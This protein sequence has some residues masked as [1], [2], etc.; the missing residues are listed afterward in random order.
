[1]QVGVR[2][3]PFND[4]EKALNAQLCVDCEGPTTILQNPP[5]LA[6][7]SGKGKEPKKFTFDAS[8]WSHDGFENDERGYSKALPGSK[9][10]DQQLVFDTF[11]KKI[12]DNAWE[13][14]HCTL[15]AY[16]QTGA[17]K[18]YSMVGYGANKGIVPISCEEIFRRIE[19]NTDAGLT[20]EV[21]VS[22]VEIYN[23]QVQDLLVRSKDRPKK[24]LDIREHNELGIYIVGVSKRAVDS[25]PAIEAVVDEGTH[26]RTVGSTLMN[27]TSSRAHTVLTIEFKQISQV[28]GQ[29]GQKLSLINLVDLA[30]SEK[31][32]QTGASGDRL[33]EGCAI[34]K[35]LSALGNVIEKLADKAT[36]KAK[37]GAIIPYRDSKLTRLLQNA[38]GGSS[39]TVM[40]CAISPASSNYEET[41]S[42]LRYADRAKRIKNT[43]AI[44]ENPQD[45]LI[46]QLREE[47]EKLRN[48]VGTGSAKGSESPEEMAAKAA[49]IAALEHALQE[50]Q[51]SFAE[52][53]SAAQKQAAA[54]KKKASSD[55]KQP[56]IANLNEDLLLTAKL[57]FPFKEGITRVGRGSA[58]EGD[59]GPEV[60]LQVPG[61]LQEH[62][63]V[64]NKE[65]ICSLT[66]KGEAALT[67]LINGTAVQDGVPATLNHGDRLA[68]GQCI[69]IFVEPSQ[70]KVADLINSGQV[71]YAMARKELQQGEVSGGPTE[72]EIK[73]S[74]E[75]AEELERK[76]REAE[77]AKD[78]AKA[79]AEELLKKREEEFKMQMEMKQKQWQEEI[80]QRKAAEDSEQLAAT[81]AAAEQA[82][83]HAEEVTRLQIEFE[84]RQ[85]NQ[86]EM[87]SRKI[88]ELERKAKKAAAEE[89]GHRQHELAMQKL[90][91]QLMTV[92]PL[93]KEANL[94]I[95][96]LQRPHRLE[97]K[98]HCE[99]TAEGKHGAVNVAAAV[100]LNG[101]RLFE[102]NP[103]TLENRVFILREL[104]QRAEEESLEVIKDLPQEEDPLWDPIQVERLIGV[105][106]VL[107]EGVLL[108]VE[109]KVD[110]RILS[111]E[112]QA[113][114]TMKVEII[115]IAKDGSLGIP[116]EE[117]V[118]EPEELLGTTMKILV[119][120]PKAVDLPEALANDVRV[121]YNYF[122]D[123]KPH[124]FDAEPGHNC[125]PEFNYKETFIQDPVTSRFLEYLQSKLVFRV[126]GKD[127]GAADAARELAR[128][129]EDARQRRAA[130]AKK[131]AEAQAA[132]LEA[133][134]SAA[135]ANAKK[136]V[137]EEKA[138]TALEATAASGQQ[139]APDLPG[140]IV[141]NDAEPG[142][143]SLAAGVDAAS[144]TSPDSSPAKPASSRTGEQAATV[145]SDGEDDPGQKKKPCGCTIS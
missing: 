100:M 49:E 35:S 125:F 129:A 28:G 96:E 39:K 12:L 58:E 21:M 144:P 67:T 130:E 126:Y 121:E 70:G 69:F 26:N 82:R 62:A 112:G 116:D 52:R 5:E 54:S 132:E 92:M 71:S 4:R 114:G 43:A 38:L 36:G 11:G 27:A 47:N 73:A 44:N 41:L 135:A 138:A 31:A 104:L 8:F 78:R 124:H 134:A 88:E 17:G 102:W 113:V 106:Q 18:S 111:S 56:H 90:E 110:A 93:V 30:G 22:M 108:Q 16:G 83:I 117:V 50:M 37:P 53:L 94:I 6:E 33:K 109:N 103:E 14:Y 99:L 86:E 15:F 120:V 97:T 105:S 10:A 141:S 80:E 84:E 63:V 118:D 3:R 24:G 32:G 66:A 9:Y 79:E 133:A 115:P 91:E 87:A 85:K 29:S 139:P 127:L 1:M 122:I 131:K 89:E 72:E 64:E 7:E 128:V 57:K 34:N 76:A 61:I 45:K 13:G 74:R 20:F 2:I 77:E 65:G 42:T 140:A 98:M 81:A 75:M 136:A 95:A 101:T 25:Y 60:A 51:Q 142:L 137:E 68:F 145:P 23:E 119:H 55:L 123:E 19:A 40:I 107:L 46:R 48:M 143:R 59:E